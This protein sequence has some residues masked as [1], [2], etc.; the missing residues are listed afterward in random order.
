MKLNS[1]SVKIA[2]VFAMEIL[3]MEL[4]FGVAQVVY[5]VQIIG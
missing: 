4:G 2:L 1:L 3:R 5:Y